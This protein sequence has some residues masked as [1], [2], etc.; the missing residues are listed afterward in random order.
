VFDH[1]NFLFFFKKQKRSM[2]QIRLFYPT[3]FVGCNWIFCQISDAA[4][5][6]PRMTNDGDDSSQRI[7]IPL[8]HLEPWTSQPSPM[9]PSSSL[10]GDDTATA[11]TVTRAEVVQS[12]ESAC[13]E[14]GFFAITGHGVP[15]TVIQNAWKASR[16]FFDLPLSV[17][18]LSK[19]D[20]EREYPY[21][22]EQSE[23]LER[24]RNNNHAQTA[25]T[26]TTN[27]PDLKE[28]FSMGPSNPQSGMPPRRF[29]SQLPDEFSRALEGYYAAMEQLALT[30]LQ[31]FAVALHLPEHWFRDKMTHHMSALRILNYFPVNVSAIQESGDKDVI[32]ASAHTD[33]GPLTILLSGGPGLQVQQNYCK[34]R[35]EEEEKENCWFDIPDDLPPNAFIINLGDLMQRWTNGTYV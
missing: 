22:Y 2:R 29:P 4:A 28:T 7:I 11:T 27:R 20:N 15:D 25:T 19:T 13:R 32:R 30:L 26:T 5:A 8:I 14:I 31:I 33:Y 18:L 16:D 3:L 12:V 6:K 24:G 1:S 17:K 21:G 35:D 9:N 23:R 34:Q 10:E